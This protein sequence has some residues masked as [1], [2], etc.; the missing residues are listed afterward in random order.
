MTADDRGVEDLHDAGEADR[1]AVFLAGTQLKIVA[2]E[3]SAARA[4]RRRDAGMA[5]T[6]GGEGLRIESAQHAAGHPRPWSWLRG[7]RVTEGLR[8][9][10]NRCVLFSS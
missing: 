7:L 3:M 1:P 5:V 10:D 2:V 9:L 4:S 6:G 8:K